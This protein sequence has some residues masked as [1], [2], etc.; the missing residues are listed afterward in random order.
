[1]GI[2]GIAATK[3]MVA[4]TMKR[5]KGAVGGK[6]FG[7]AIAQIPNPQNIYSFPKRAKSDKFQ[8]YVPNPQAIQQGKDDLHEKQDVRA[9]WRALRAQAEAKEGGP[10]SGRQWD[11]LRKSIQRTTAL[12][13]RQAVVA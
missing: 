12:V 11:K 3:N 5:I 2:F 9:K 7:N 4:R 1:M 10:M 6:V 13:E 8:Y